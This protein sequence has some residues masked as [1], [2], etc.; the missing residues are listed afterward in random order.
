MRSVPDPFSG[1]VKGAGLRGHARLSEDLKR[2]QQYYTVLRETFE[3]EE[4]RGSGGGGIRDS[5][6]TVNF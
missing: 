1:G 4:F 3:E 2:N 5:L 6:C